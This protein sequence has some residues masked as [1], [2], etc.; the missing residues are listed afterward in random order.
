RVREVPPAGTAQS[1][2][3]PP[4]VT[5]GA[6]DTLATVFSVSSPPSLGPATGTLAYTENDGA[7]VIDSTITASSN[8][9]TLT[10]ATITFADGYVNGEDSLGFSDQNG[11]THTFDVTNGTLT[12]SGSSSV[13]NYQTAL[14]S[15]IYTDGSDDPSNATRTLSI[16]VSEGSVNS[17]A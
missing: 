7:K 6:S 2:P 5:V 11:I 10:G 16:I 4:D 17:T 9:T 1:I 3:N 8:G 14:R 15:I 13:A 12:L